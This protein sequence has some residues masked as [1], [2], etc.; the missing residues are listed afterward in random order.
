MYAEDVMNEAEVQDHEN[1]FL[2]TYKVQ[3]QA[4]PYLMTDLLEH[5]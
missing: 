4:L 3:V 1:L 5:Y 2:F